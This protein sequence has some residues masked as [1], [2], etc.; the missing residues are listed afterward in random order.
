MNQFKKRILLILTVIIAVGMSS[1]KC[2][3][4][5]EVVDHNIKEEMT[6]ASNEDTTREQQRVDVDDGQIN[7]ESTSKNNTTSGKDESTKIDENSS[8]NSVS[9]NEATTTPEK[10]NTISKENGTSGKEQSTS[11][12]GNNAGGASSSASNNTPKPDGET[13]KPSEEA[14]TKPSEEATTKPSEKPTV[15]NDDIIVTNKTIEEILTEKLDSK[16]YNELQKKY[17]LD[18][19]HKLD[20][21]YDKYANLYGIAGLP[22][23]DVYLKEHLINPLDEIIEFNLIDRNSAEAQQLLELGNSV[24]WLTMSA[25][26]NTKNSVTLLYAADEYDSEYLYHEISHAQNTKCVNSVE[27]YYFDNVFHDYRFD[28]FIEGHA[29]FHEQF[30]NN[31]YQKNSATWQVKNSNGNTIMY[32]K[33]NGIGYIQPYNIY[34]NLLL[35]AG[36]DT[37]EEL[38]KTADFSVLENSLKN[39]YSSEIANNLIH[40]MKNNNTSGDVVNDSRYNNCVKF[41]NAILDALKTKV[42]KITTKSEMEQFLQFYKLYQQYLLP[43]VF[44]T[45]NKYVSKEI[46]Y[47]VFNLSDLENA[48]INKASQLN[49]VNGNSNEKKVVM[50]AI[51]FSRDKLYGLYHNEDFELLSLP[52]LYND[53]EVVSVT[54]VGGNY[55]VKLSYEDVLYDFGS[56]TLEMEYVLDSSYNVTKVQNKNIIYN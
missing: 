3:E 20:K 27:F 37:M 15:P 13:T 11:T 30:V 31:L 48:I 38:S 9:N 49:V 25:I 55:V 35:V 51:L 26:D 34:A 29:T 56:I 43:R 54:S 47:E 14:T 12:S 33:Q 22:S 53:I 16:N 32:N 50:K 24:A 8:S 6:T 18:I 40:Q 5:A 44:E 21:N 36:Y 46:T 41:Q 45:D 7:D 17:I 23:K 42:E 19:Y 2:A 10:D 39:Q 1:C 28:V 52:I 4:K